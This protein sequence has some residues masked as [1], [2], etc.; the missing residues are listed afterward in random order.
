[1]IISRCFGYWFKELGPE[2][3]CDLLPPPAKPASELLLHVQLSRAGL[4]LWPLVSHRT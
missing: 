1:M 4:M 3:V 2:D